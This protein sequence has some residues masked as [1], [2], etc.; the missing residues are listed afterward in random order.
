[1]EQ[2]TLAARHHALDIVGPSA[3]VALGLLHPGVVQVGHGKAL[4]HA[5]PEVGLRLGAA[6]STFWP[7]CSA[8]SSR[9]LALHRGRG[10]NGRF[11]RLLGGGGG[12]GSPGL[13]QFVADAGC[14]IGLRVAQAASSSVRLTRPTGAAV[15]SGGR[16]RKL[17]F[18]S[19][20][21]ANTCTSSAASGSAAWSRTELRTSA[22]R[23]RRKRVD[24]GLTRDAGG[25]GG[26]G[27]PRSS[28][29]QVL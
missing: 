2:V 13:G 27:R 5:A 20:R 11:G 4:A 17:F 12:R 18:H 19:R 25:Q 14:Q 8:S 1:M 6:R 7:G 16:H 28:W 10:G 23:L 3:V 22:A 29:H 9:S 24:L 26:A 15:Q 21:L